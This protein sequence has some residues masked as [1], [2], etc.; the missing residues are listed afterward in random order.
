M[1]RW[2]PS[3]SF[4]SCHFRDKTTTFGAKHLNRKRNSANETPIGSS[5]KS[6]GTKDT[7]WISW[8]PLALWHHKMFNK[9]ALLAVYL[10]YSSS[11]LIELLLP[12]NSIR[13]FG[14]GR[15]ESSRCESRR[16]CLIAEKFWP[17]THQH[18][19][20]W[21]APHELCL[22]KPS[23]LGNF[24]KIHSSLEI[25]AVW[26]EYLTSCSLQKLFPT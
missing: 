6:G 26:E 16:E 13:L 21:R 9:A 25:R 5:L 1:C 12:Y 3:C 20:Y 17:I 8:R 24:E 14:C 19:G 4:M 10:H 11:K 23:W 22:Q 2:C 15:F 18:I 7:N